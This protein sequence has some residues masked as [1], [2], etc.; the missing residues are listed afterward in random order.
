MLTTEQRGV[1]REIRT[2]LGVIETFDAH[3]EIERR[4]AFLVEHVRASGLAALVLGISGG[5]DS[6]TAGCLAQ[7]A[8]QALR[9]QLRA[10][11]ANLLGG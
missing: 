10:V 3:A 11:R 6:L 7:R 9:A 5:V 4:V 8:A 2:A 1:Q